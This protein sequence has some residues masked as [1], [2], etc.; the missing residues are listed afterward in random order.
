MTSAANTD[1]RVRAYLEELETA[2]R[3]LPAPQAAELMEQITAHLD[4][5]LPPGSSEAAVV[6]VLRRLGS[7]A[8]LAAEAQSAAK[9]DADA[10]STA[11]LGA[12]ARST[13]NLDAESPEAAPSR[14][15][16]RPL[17]H[18]FSRRGWS[19]I[20]AGIALVCVL[21]TF[22]G[23]YLTTPSITLGGLSTWWFPQDQAAAVL[24]STLGAEA[25]TVP[26]RR[27][28][29]QGFVVEVEN[30]SGSAQTILGAAPSSDSPTALIGMGGVA[31]VEV[32]VSTYANYTGAASDVQGMH[33][34]T[35]QTLEPG[36]FRFIRVLWKTD[37][38]SLSSG[39]VTTGSDQ[40][41]LEVQ[42]GLFSRQEDLTLD[43][44]W[45]L[46][47]GFDCPTS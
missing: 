10:P 14:T 9:L 22:L 41:N 11:N 25:S 17:R 38:C 36:Q 40:L 32:G 33:F 39:A 26:A 6:V 7:P 28:Q 18:R 19:A 8:K 15:P 46:S 34:T 16:A 47:F 13:P 1:A 3:V 21:S 45:Q 2:L 4:E 43:P 5:A 23:L 29:W 42:V 24:S 30:P 27:E 37:S 31:D 44:G 35:Q 12:G 20:V